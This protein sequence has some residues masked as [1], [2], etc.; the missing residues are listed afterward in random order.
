MKNAAPSIG[1]QKLTSPPPISTII[2]TNPDWWRL[3]T[4]GYADC[5]AMAKS[6]PAS[7]AI[8]AEST[9]TSHL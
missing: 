3:I 5:C 8:A 9:N 1:P 6:A 2:T 4:L 7:P